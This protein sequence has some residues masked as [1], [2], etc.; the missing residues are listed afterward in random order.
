MKEMTECLD[1]SHTFWKNLSYEERFPIFVERLDSKKASSLLSWWNSIVVANENTYPDEPKF[2]SKE[3][4]RRNEI[5]Q[6]Y[7]PVAKKGDNPIV[8]LESYL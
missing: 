2:E 3:W 7:I 4:I 6:E 1:K 5:L 8:H